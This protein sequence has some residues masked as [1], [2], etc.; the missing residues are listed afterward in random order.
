MRERQCGDMN[1]GSVLKAVLKE[2]RILQFEESLPLFVVRFG[3]W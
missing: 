3:S 1:E 2:V